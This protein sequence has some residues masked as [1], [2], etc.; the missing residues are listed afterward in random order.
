[1]ADYN[2]SNT[3]V[4]VFIHNPKPGTKTQSAGEI[5]KDVYDHIAGLDSTNNKVISISHCALKGDKILTM[6]VSGA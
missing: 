6:V 4:K 1:M 2:A 3:D 5:A